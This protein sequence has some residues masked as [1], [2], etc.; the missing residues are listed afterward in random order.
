MNCQRCNGLMYQMEL[1]DS[2]GFERLRASVCV[3][4]GEMI[5]PLIKINRQRAMSADILLPKRIP[6]HSKY[7]RKLKHSMSHRKATQ[8]SA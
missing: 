5:D 1:R 3:I 8:L 4:C 2:K 7:W 6:R